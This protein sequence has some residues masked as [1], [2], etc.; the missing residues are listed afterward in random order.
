MVDKWQTDIKR[1]TGEKQ[2]VQNV[3][4]QRSVAK[5]QTFVRSEIVTHH[6]Q[7]WGDKGRVSLVFDIQDYERKTIEECTREYDFYVR[8]RLSSRLNVSLPKEPAIS[9]GEV[10]R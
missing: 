4:K 1:T 5:T 6:V 8:N 3:R 9:S 7:D 10:G 2:L